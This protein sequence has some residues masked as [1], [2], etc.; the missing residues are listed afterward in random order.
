MSLPALSIDALLLQRWPATALGCLF[1]EVTVT[2]VCQE[3]WT[4]Y[5]NTLA[6]ELA[7]V[8]AEKA[9]TD[10]PGISEAR[11]A[12]KAFGMDPGRWRVSSEALYRRVRQGKELYQINSV[13]DAN[14][15]LSLETGF[16]LG[17]YDC[18]RI[19]GDIVLRL[20]AE[21]ESYQGLGK[22]A[23]P[24]HNMPLLSD[25][26]GPFGSPVS[27]SGRACITEATRMVCTVLYGFSNKGALEAALEKAADA[28]PRFA[29][30]RNLETRLV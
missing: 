11:S 19:R 30:A 7:A 21:G 25:A 8:L 12:F 10:L 15:V 27:D 1:Y 24:L 9:L 5:R 17:S 16:S 23:I 2:P 13:V 3:L 26:E 4:Y 6:P 29:G 20:G 22:G 14:N 28:L 18:A